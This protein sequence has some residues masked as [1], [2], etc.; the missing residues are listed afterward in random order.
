MKILFRRIT[1]NLASLKKID[2]KVWITLGV[3]LIVLIVFFVIGSQS[4]AASSSTYQTEPAKR[5]TLTASVGATGTVHA[6]QS[7]ALTWQ[8]SGRVESVTAL[9][10]DSVKADEVLASLT[11]TS[12]S[13]NVILAEADLVSAQKNLEDLLTSD[14]LQAK[15]DE[16][17]A[18]AKQALE[19][20]QE[21]V[22]SIDFPRASDNL[23]QQTQARIDLAKK[24]LTLAE[25][26]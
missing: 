22:D 4:S 19:D 10:G 8:T 14:T 20:A 3:I 2:R 5:G 18:A 25:D 9:V 6:R 7:A 15:A 23:V 13:Q 12:M 21:K 11:Q 26:N 17:L 24:E 1:M 16:N